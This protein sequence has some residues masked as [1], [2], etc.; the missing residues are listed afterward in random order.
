MC[1]KISETNCVTFR[2]SNIECC[3]YVKRF[4]LLLYQLTDL[5]LPNYNSH[6]I[7]HA[8]VSQPDRNELAATKFPLRSANEL[9]TDDCT[10]AGRITERIGRLCRSVMIQYE[11][12]LAYF[13]LVK[14]K[15]SKISS[16]NISW[17]PRGNL[18]PLIGGWSMPKTGLFSLEI[19]SLPIVQD[20]VLTPGPVWIIAEMSPLLE[21]DPRTNQPVDSHYTDWAIPPTLFQSILSASVA[22]ER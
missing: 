17:I 9:Q 12:I 21:F 18:H 1:K 14:T 16:S 11:C 7:Q 2:S 20:S 15:E 13:M 5:R 22:Q 10:T 8:A 6:S 4:A 3:R 19:D